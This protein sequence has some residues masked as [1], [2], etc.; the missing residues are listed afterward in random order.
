MGCKV[1]SEGKTRPGQKQQWRT[2]DPVAFVR[3]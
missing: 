3:H 1:T 2:G